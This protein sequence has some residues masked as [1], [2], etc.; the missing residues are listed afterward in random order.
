M[1][2]RTQ[3]ASLVRT[4]LADTDFQQLFPG[5]TFFQGKDVPNYDSCRDPKQ[6]LVYVTFANRADVEMAQ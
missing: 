4:Q 5:A 1:S 6:C 3:R 2:C